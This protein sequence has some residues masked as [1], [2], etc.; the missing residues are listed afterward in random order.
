MSDMTLRQNASSSP[1][2]GLLWLLLCLVALISLLPS[3]RLLIA[4]LLD[5]RQGGDSSLWRV[6]SN[7]AT[8]TALYNSLYTSGLGTLISAAWQLVRLL[9]GVDQYPPQAG[10]GIPV[11]A[12]DDDPASGYRSELAAALRSEQHSA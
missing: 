5:W 3:L 12:A 11:Y 7:P 8:W 9:P 10:V 4:A 6:L 1:V 2:K